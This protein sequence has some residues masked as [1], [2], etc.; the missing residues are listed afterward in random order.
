[1]RIDEHGFARARALAEG[2]GVPPERIVAVVAEL[3]ERGLVAGEDL[4]PILTE[5]G[6]TLAGRAVAARRELLNEAL[7]D[8][9]AGRDAAV[10]ELLR[11]LA[12][13]LTG[14]RP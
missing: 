7:A 4:G 9:S 1:V 8:E 11:R 14:D 3:R 6:H 10:D 5:A 2:D 13:E 12:R